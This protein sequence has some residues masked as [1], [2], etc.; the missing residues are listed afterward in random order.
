[1]KKIIDFF[2]YNKFFLLLLFLITN[3][4]F[5]YIHFTHV[6]WDFAVYILNAKYLINSGYFEILRPI[7]PSFLI[8][9]LGLLFTFKFAGYLYVVFVTS[10]HL[11]SSY[12]FCKKFNFNLN[13]YYF[14]FLV[15]SFFLFSI[16]FGTELLM[17][18]LIQFYFAFFDSAFSGLF[19]SLAILTRY[20]G[21]IY[22]PFLL[23]KNI[24]LIF[25]KIFYFSI[26]LILTG[27]FYYLKFGN[28]FIS[29]L[30]NYSLNV[31]FRNY[32]SQNFSF[33]HLFYILG[34]LL[35]LTIFYF[36]K[37]F[38]KLNKWDYFF[39][40]FSL[41]TLYSYYS[42]PGKE[43]RYLF[44]II[45][46]F[47]YFS[48]KFVFELKEK[49][50]LVIIGIYFILIFVI[51][52]SLPL[53]P[54]NIETNGPED[55][56]LANNLTSGCM[57]SSNAWVFLNYYGGHSKPAPWGDLFAYEIY[58]GYKIILFNSI[59]E[60]E[61]L[62]NESFFWDKPL[63]YSNEVFSIYGTGKCRNLERIDT[64]YLFILN[65]TVYL[66]YNETY[67]DYSFLFR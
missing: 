45:L 46:P 52:I 47:V 60:P 55:Y 10:L 48:Y 14:L 56:K 6:G 17:L 23:S 20:N 57:V 28:P 15:P 3:F 67:N 59:N 34:P 11:L 27:V 25:K 41:V 39:I 24:K 9:I 40:L 7:F 29:F 33:F 66:L 65:R 18:S 51:F 42:V 1:M 35:F 58:Q 22:T 36:I 13:L 62:K 8:F 31:Y 21:L 61:Y 5:I 49:Y 26:P 38:R 64:S 53:Y 43:A 16:F 54:L 50:K 4:V 37:N 19:L 32:Y 2:L 12:Y 30:D 44:N 63:I